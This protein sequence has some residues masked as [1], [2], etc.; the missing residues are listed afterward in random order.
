MKVNSDSINRDISFNSIYTSHT[1]KKGLKFAAENGALFKATATVAFAA[2]RPV[3]IWLTPKADK[4]NKKLASA[5]SIASSLIGFGLML[6]CSVP[7][8]SAVKKI[9]INPEKYLNKET[10]NILKD[11]VKDLD[12][13]K[14]Y[15]FAT[16][17]FKLGIDTLAAI[18][19]SILTV[20][21]IPSVM[22]IF[23][24][25]P[26]EQNNITFKGKSNDFLAKS[27]GNII[28]KKGVRN[29]AEKYKDTN[30]PMHM[31]AATDTL[32]TLAFVQ[33]TNQSR[34]IEEN[35]KKVLIYNSLISTALSIF[36]GYTI[37]KLLDKP[38]AKFIEKF[39]Q[40]NASDK[41]LSK[42]IQGIKIAKP[43]LILGT[44]YYI[45]IPLISTFL[46]EKTDKK[47]SKKC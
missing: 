31:V 15:I 35:R 22:N 20:T 46:A 29:F 12:S 17:L 45:F 16:Q 6:A 9:D 25:K 4:E 47:Y 7:L 38:T 18:P 1:L 10:I 42:Q 13:S 39:K 40:K 37:D 44:I 33:Q 32:A 41:N 23:S 27:I 5:K 21:A 28:N 43:I 34:K 14:G 2:A 26:K 30:F 3:S 8:A 11:N 24:Q 36:V 19:K